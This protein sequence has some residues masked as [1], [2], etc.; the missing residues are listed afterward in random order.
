MLAAWVRLRAEGRGCAVGDATNPG[1]LRRAMARDSAKPINGSLLGAYAP[2]PAQ[3]RAP[4]GPAGM[5]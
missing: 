2:C 1:D 5:L 4:Y 3:A